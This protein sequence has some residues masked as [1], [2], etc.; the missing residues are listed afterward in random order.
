MRDKHPSRRKALSTKRLSRVASKRRAKLP[1]SC[2]R[3]FWLVVSH[4]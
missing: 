1:S 4:T 3:L 2:I